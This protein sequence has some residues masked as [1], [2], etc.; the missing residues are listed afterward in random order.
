M[1]LLPGPQGEGVVFYTPTSHSFGSGVFTPAV[2][3]ELAPID[4]TDP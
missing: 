2:S 3:D 4:E 1:C